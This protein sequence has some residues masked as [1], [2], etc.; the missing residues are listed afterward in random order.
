MSD[1]AQ[2]ARRWGWTILLSTGSISLTFNIAHALHAVGASWWEQLLAVLYGV[3]PV[4]VALMLSHLIGIQQGGPVKRA[5]T[6]LVFIAAMGLSVSAIA[7]V[8]R[9]IVGDAGYAG[10]VFAIMLD[11]ASLMGL[12]EILSAGSHARTVDERTAADKRGQDRTAPDAIE[13]DRTELNDVTQNRTAEPPAVPAAAPAPYAQPS[14]TEPIRTEEARTY[15]P[16]D[17]TYGAYGPVDEP[18]TAPAEERF[19]AL[20]S[21]LMDRAEFIRGLAEQIRTAEQNGQAWRPDYDALQRT[22]G[23]SRSYCEKAVREARTAAAASGSEP[24]MEG[25]Y[26]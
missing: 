26:G 4:L 11:V 17:G 15:G 8:L 24:L 18:R 20:I 16:V 1:Q 21:R 12:A 22:T 9:P 6:F 2:A 14:R 3:S 23:R 10:Y 7:E 19:P 5:I 25:T 13:R